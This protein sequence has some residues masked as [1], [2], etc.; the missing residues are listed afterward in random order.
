MIKLYFLLYFAC[1]LLKKGCASTKVHLEKKLFL[2]TLVHDKR[3]TLVH[4]NFACHH[5]G[6]CFFCTF[7]KVHWGQIPPQHIGTSFLFIPADWYNSCYHPCIV[8]HDFC[9]LL[10]MGKKEFDILENRKKHAVTEILENIS[11]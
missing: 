5:I 10:C 1:I 4:R 9:H 2:I 6:T 11:S 7:T 8:L 3:V